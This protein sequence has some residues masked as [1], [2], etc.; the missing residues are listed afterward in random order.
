MFL[1]TIRTVFSNVLGSSTSRAVCGQ[2]AAHIT[3]RHLSAPAAVR[4]DR[5]PG[6]VLGHA[7]VTFTFTG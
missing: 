6:A 2:T 1:L 4:R 7:V 5:R 3:L